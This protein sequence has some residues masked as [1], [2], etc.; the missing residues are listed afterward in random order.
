M[1]GASSTHDGSWTGARAFIRIYRD[2]GLVVA[3]MSN[4]TNHTQDGDVW[5]LATSLGNA[6]LAP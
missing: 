2:D 4:R 3:I 1:A 5:G 6:V